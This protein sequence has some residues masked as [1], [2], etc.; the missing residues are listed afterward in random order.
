MDML[1]GCLHSDRSTSWSAL[2]T[3]REHK[4]PSPLT[5]RVK[6]LFHN[7]TPR[8][9]T[10]PITTPTLPRLQKQ[11]S[12]QVHQAFLAQDAP[13][14]AA[15]VWGCI[16]PE[17]G[18]D[19]EMMPASSPL[20]GPTSSMCSTRS[21]KW[22]GVAGEEGAFPLQEFEFQSYSAFRVGTKLGALWG[23]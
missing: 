14:E 1:F 19:T 8:A 3:S 9:Q 7:N 15:Q 13:K 17:P 21:G 22:R 18:W 20:P 23:N 2:S 16:P 4:Y 5:L 12:C 10:V 11:Q 6:L